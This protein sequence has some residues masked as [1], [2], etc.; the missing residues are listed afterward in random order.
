MRQELELSREGIECD[1][2]GAER[3][4][5]V[6]MESHPGP[7]EFSSARRPQSLD[8]KPRRPSFKQHGK[9]DRRV[10]RSYNFEHLSFDTLVPTR[11][12]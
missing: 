4:D 7:R 12:D 3:S 9:A 11:L 2:G 10:R 6:S 8:V 5:R 1:V